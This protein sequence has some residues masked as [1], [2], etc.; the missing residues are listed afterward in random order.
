MLSLEVCFRSELP[1]IVF[2]K[3]QDQTNE[4]IYVHVICIEHTENMMGVMQS[5][6][7]FYF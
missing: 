1:N 6:Q 4:F 5:K 2:L 7:H 3:K